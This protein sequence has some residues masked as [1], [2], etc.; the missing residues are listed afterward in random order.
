MAMFINYENEAVCIKYKNVEA[1]D[2]TVIILVNCQGNPNLSSVGRYSH[3][4]DFGKGIYPYLP[5]S[6][7]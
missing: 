2:I 5:P 4:I 7:G 1:R 6:N 3:F